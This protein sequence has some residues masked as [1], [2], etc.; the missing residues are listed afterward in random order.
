LAAVG[1]SSP[2]EFWGPAV[3]GLKAP[4]N[5]DMAGAGPDVGEGA[6]AAEAW[7]RGIGEGA[8]AW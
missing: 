5:P 1:V 3:P 6:E 8:D 2:A 7:E 4:G